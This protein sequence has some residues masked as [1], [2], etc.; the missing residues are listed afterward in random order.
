MYMFRFKTMENC[1]NVIKGDA[2]FFDS[3]SVIIIPCT[4]HINIAKEPIKKLPIWIKLPKL[5]VR[6]WGEESLFKIVG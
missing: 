3:K 2:Q 1:T 4:P 6:Y 5:D